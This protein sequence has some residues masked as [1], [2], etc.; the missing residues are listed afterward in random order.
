MN[1]RR[2]AALLLVGL[3]LVCGAQGGDSDQLKPAPPSPSG[4]SP[5]KP[6]PL[7]DSTPS[8]GQGI[9]ERVPPK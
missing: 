4:S 6:D 8:T 2:A 1:T 5:T 7:R 3:I 9:D